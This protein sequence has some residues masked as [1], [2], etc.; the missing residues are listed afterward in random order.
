[1]PVAHNA[2][3]GCPGLLGTYL[4]GGLTVLARSPAPDEVF[5]LVVEHG[6]TLT[7]L[8]PPLVRIWIDSVE[9]FDVDVSGVLLQIG[10][11]KLP[12]ELARRIRPVLGCEVTHWFGM[13]EGFSRSPVP[14]T[15][16]TSCSSPR[17]LR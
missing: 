7:T 4:A 5:P 6:V 12:L 11:A 2:A 9:L 8:M 1:L 15:R 13:A 10:S 3:L 17:A 16:T 14:V